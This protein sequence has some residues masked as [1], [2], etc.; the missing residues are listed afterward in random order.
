MQSFIWE[1]GHESWKVVLKENWRKK[2][3]RGKGV[4]GTDFASCLKKSCNWNA[5]MS[6]TCIGF[7]RQSTVVIRLF[8]KKKDP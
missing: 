1:K 3:D 5:C 7:Q 8:W 6:D 2:E 4:T